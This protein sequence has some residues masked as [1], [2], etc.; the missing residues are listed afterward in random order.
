MNKPANFFNHSP[1]SFTAHLRFLPSSL[2]GFLVRQ[3]KLILLSF[4]LEVEECSDF[5]S[6][7]LLLCKNWR[8]FEENCLTD[9]K[10][11][12]RERPWWWT[13]KDPDICPCPNSLFI[14]KKLAY[15][16]MFFSPQYIFFKK[17]IKQIIK[18]FGPHYKLDL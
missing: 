8:S 4:A 14:F 17:Y 7:S 12:E 13:E 3:T 16:E 10:E 5:F 18:I 15:V 1:L 9:R 11:N 6:F 2:T